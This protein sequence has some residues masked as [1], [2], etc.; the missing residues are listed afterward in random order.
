[1]KNNLTFNRI[2]GGGNPLLTSQ[3]DP[4]RQANVAKPSRWSRITWLQWAAIATVALLAVAGSPT[5]QMAAGPWL[6]RASWSGPRRAR[7]PRAA[8]AR[9][10][11]WRRRRR[12]RPY[13]SLRRKSGAAPSAKATAG[14]RALWVRPTRQLKEVTGRVMSTETAARRSNGCTLTMVARKFP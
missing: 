12:S 9:P 1:M 6:A 13:L 8:R 10:G 5:V 11:R 7:V 14:C 2:N 3:T 4:A